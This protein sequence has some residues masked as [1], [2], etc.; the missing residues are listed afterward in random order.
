MSACCAV[1][2]CVP[3]ERPTLISMSERK[4][5]LT[6]VSPDRHGNGAAAPGGAGEAASGL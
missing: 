1:C 2:A 4:Q 6:S 5:V 3:F